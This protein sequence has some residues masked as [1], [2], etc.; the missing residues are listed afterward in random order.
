M[1]QMVPRRSI[2]PCNK[3]CVS[4]ESKNQ[5]NQEAVPRV[6][7]KNKLGIKKGRKALSHFILPFL[8]FHM[9]SLKCF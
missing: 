6:N 1:R 7:G 2:D 4:S 9:I 5:R 3:R 8:F